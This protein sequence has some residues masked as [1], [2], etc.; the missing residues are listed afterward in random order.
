MGSKS[1]SLSAY[2]DAR[3]LLEYALTDPGMTY[4]LPT[5][6]KA[7]N[8]KQR[9]NTYRAMLISIDQE[10]LKGVAGARGMSRYDDIIIRQVNAEGKSDRQ[11]TILRFD[12]TAL[13]GILRNSDGD[14]ID[15]R[16]LDLEPTADE[17]LP[18]D[19]D[20]IVGVTDHD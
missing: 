20:S 3:Q 11:G 18:P 9:C 14:K 2:N 7:A 10:R 15:P 12:T 19:F 4:E 6:G 13:E 8:M 1:K 16:D 17:I 5:A